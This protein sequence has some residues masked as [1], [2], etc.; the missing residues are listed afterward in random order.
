MG[1]HVDFGL[2]ETMPNCLTNQRESAKD[3]LWKPAKVHFI[4][5]TDKI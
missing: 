5:F 2:V 4:E 1:E 3:T